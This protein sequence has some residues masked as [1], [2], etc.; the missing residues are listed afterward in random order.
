MLKRT[1]FTI[2]DWEQKKCSRL[3]FLFVVF[4]NGFRIRPKYMEHTYT[5]KAKC[6][7]FLKKKSKKVKNKKEIIHRFFILKG[8]LREYFIHGLF[9]SLCSYEPLIVMLVLSQ[10]AL[11]ISLYY[12][13]ID[14][15]NNLLSTSVYSM[16]L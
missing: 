13:W 5:Y 6:K 15:N 3:V 2:N 14:T 12:L 1:L 7:V 8:K 10:S 4:C 11:K 9:F 16:R